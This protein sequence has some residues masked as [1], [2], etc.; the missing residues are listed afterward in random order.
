MEKDDS[1][2]TEVPPKT[3]HCFSG[4]GG[5]ESTGKYDGFGNT[6]I[7]RG[8]NVKL[9]LDCTTSSFQLSPA[10]YTLVISFLNIENYGDKMADLIERAITIPDERKEVMEMCLAS[11]STG[12]FQPI[13]LPGIQAK[14][15]YGAPNISMHI[16]TTGAFQQSPLHSSTIGQKHRPGKAGGGW[17]DDFDDIIQKEFKATESKSPTN[18]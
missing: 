1:T 3:Q 15:S 18:T 4:M 11:P 7:Q 12:D 10:K 16:S 17:E 8:M 14:D 2:E 6:P 9:N 5:G 13:N